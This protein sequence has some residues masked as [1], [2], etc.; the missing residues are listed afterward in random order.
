VEVDRGRPRA[1]AGTSLRLE[2]PPA[3]NPGIECVFGWEF[4]VYKPYLYDGLV[5]LARF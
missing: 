5:L 3:E 2:P 4:R 1:L